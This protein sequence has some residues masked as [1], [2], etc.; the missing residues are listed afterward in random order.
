MVT[1][2]IGIVIAIVVFILAIRNRKW[3]ATRV[4][5]VQEGLGW[6]WFVIMWT[7]PP[8]LYGLGWAMTTIVQT[9]AQIIPGFEQSLG[10]ELLILTVFAVLGVLVQWLTSASPVTRISQL[11]ADHV[12][13]SAWAIITAALAGAMWGQ[14]ELTYWLLFPAIYAAIELILTGYT[15]VWNAFQRDQMQVQEEGRK[16]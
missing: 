12:I 1:L 6:A 16:I 7:F 2:I 13:S 11:V 14:G 5:K 9:V 10:M 4:E 8:V 15:I 3:L